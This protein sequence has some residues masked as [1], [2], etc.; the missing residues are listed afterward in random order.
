MQLGEQKFPQNPVSRWRGLTQL[1]VLVSCT[2]H[3][4]TGELCA[5]DISELWDDAH[6]ATSL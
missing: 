6:P 1:Q 3:E 5:G 2:L 4:S